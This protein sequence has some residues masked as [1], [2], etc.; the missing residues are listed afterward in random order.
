MIKERVEFGGDCLVTAESAVRDRFMT[1]RFEFWA[2]WQLTL[3]TGHKF[4]AKF[5]ISNQ[6]KKQVLGKCCRK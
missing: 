5:E 3:I 1:V 2:V 4:R 6:S